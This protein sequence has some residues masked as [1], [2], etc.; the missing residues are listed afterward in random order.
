MDIPD[1][2]CVV[3]FMVALSLPILI[4]RFGRAGRSGQPVIAILLAEPS[5]FQVKKKNNVNKIKEEPIDEDEVELSLDSLG[6]EDKDVVTE[7][8]KKV[9]SGM[10]DWC[11]TVGCRCDI[12]DNYFKNPRRENGASFGGVS[13]LLDYSVCLHF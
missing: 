5:V 2:D 4:Q 6:L 11:L 9:E 3:Q 13:N 12:T 8:R 1:I 7:Y 10:Q